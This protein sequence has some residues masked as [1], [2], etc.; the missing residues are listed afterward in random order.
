ML[1]NGK[2]EATAIPEESDLTEVGEKET[3]CVK[4]TFYIQTPVESHGQK[5]VW[6]GWATQAALGRTVE[7]LRTMGWTGND[8]R[9]LSSIGKN[10]VELV[11]EG[12]EYKG[13]MYPRVKFVNALGGRRVVVDPTKKL[14]MAKSLA[15]QIKAMEAAASAPPAPA[16][17]PTPSAVRVPP[18]PTAA[19]H[20]PSDADVP[21]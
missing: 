14:A 6:D 12:E 2:Y 11:I 5:I 21:F 18:K 15:A 20:G 8:L 13:K 19:T 17:W 9:D 3:P 10:N 7:A 4:V 1:E 16:A